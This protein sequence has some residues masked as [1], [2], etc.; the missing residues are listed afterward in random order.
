MFRE[1]RRRERKSRW[2]EQSQVVIGQQVSAAKEGPAPV[3]RTKED[4]TKLTKAQRKKLKKKRRKE[5]KRKEGD[6][7]VDT[8]NDSAG[9]RINY[10]S[11]IGSL[12]KFTL[13]KNFFIPGKTKKIKVIN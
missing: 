11:F 10:R 3:P 13:F 6:S 7:G 4:G 12:T 1:K 9:N 8:G 5:E 2:T